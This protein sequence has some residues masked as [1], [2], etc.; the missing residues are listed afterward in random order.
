[1]ALIIS[2]IF[3]IFPEKRQLYHI[4]GIFAAIELIGIIAIGYFVSGLVI[5]SIFPLLILAIINQVVY[6][7]TEEEEDWKEEE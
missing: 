1:M 3:W 4:A 2:L 5:V 7:K 6:K